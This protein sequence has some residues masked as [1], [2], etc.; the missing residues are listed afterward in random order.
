[1]AGEKSTQDAFLFFSIVIPAHNEAKYIGTTIASL[2]RLDYP[3]E[4]LQVII[5]ENGSTD[6][7]LETIAACAPDWFAVTSVPKAGV[8]G[9]R[10]AGIRL[11]ARDSD[12]VI[13]LDADTFFA[14]SFLQELNHFLQQHHGE[15]LGTGMVSLLP[16][17]DSRRAR[18][19]YHFYNFAQH[20]TGTTR[21]LQ[22]IRRD[23]LQTLRYDEELDFG[24]DTK[25]LR[26]CD[27]RSRHF[28]LETTSAFSSTRRFQGNG[29]V[30]QLCSWIYL[31]ALPYERQ[32]HAR[33]KVIR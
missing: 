11:L 24:E 32:K 2:T 33:Y 26:Q 27:H 25:M 23:L 6:G 29:W 21:S 10:N 5:A 3:Q 28:Y 16:I 17:P 14:P 8:S 4:R 12:W 31:F 19:W 13:F 22:I 9:A 20:V 1:M 30:R 7:T 15:N 18:A